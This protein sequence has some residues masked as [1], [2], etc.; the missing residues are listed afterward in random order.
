MQSRNFGSPHQKWARVAFIFVSVILIS[1]TTRTSAAQSAI[2]STRCT[3]VLFGTVR[4][5]SGQPAVGLTVAAWPLGVDLS[6]M[7]PEA[8]TDKAGGYTFAHVCP[9]RYTVLP[10]DSRVGYPDISPL[11]AEFL[12]GHRPQEVRLSASHLNA[13]LS[14][15]LSPPP[16]TI[17]LHATSSLS[18]AEIKNFIVQFVVPRKPRPYRVRYAF[19]DSV[20][21]EV[22]V[23]S[24]ESFSFVVTARGFHKGAKRVLV[25]A[26]GN[27]QTVD[28]QVTPLHKR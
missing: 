24:G 10:D 18:G 7:L 19:D 4:N 5:R 12:C 13:E 1:L 17:V 2:Q 8:T 25:I 21:R 28:M 26:A 20:D 23:P 14:F 27:N 3:G 16:A 9:G 22:R 6:A 11:E 15:R